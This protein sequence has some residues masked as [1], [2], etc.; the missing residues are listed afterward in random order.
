MPGVRIQP[1]DERLAAAGLTRGDMGSRP[2]TVRDLSRPMQGPPFPPCFICGHHDV[3][4]YHLG[5]RRD[6][7]GVPILD[8]DGTTIVSE[9]IWAGMQRMF[10]DGGF[11]KVNVVEAPPTQGFRLPTASILVTPATM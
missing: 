11:E 7:Q 6:A 2:V 8:A 4:T 10:D 3:K 1:S 9:T 5:E